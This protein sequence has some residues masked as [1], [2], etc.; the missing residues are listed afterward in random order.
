MLLGQGITPGAGKV[1]G[2]LLGGIC[3]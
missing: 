1:N 3:L 2:D